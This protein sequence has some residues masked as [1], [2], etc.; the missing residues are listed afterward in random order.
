MKFLALTLSTAFNTTSNVSQKVSL[1]TLSVSLETT[2]LWAVRFSLLLIFLASLHATSL[3]NLVTSVFL[4]RN[5]LFK[6]L[7]SILSLSVHYTLPFSE[8]PSPVSAKNF[9]N[10]QPSAPAPTRNSFVDC[11]FFMNFPP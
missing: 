3:L 2:Y 5:C 9:R 7:T 10:S 1:Y 8:Q 11:N 6:L 4:N